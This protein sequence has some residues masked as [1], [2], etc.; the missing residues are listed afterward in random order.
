MMMMK[1]IENNTN[2]L[3]LTSQRLKMS[4]KENSLLYQISN[5]RKQKQSEPLSWESKREK[6]N[7]WTNKNN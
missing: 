6:T 3:P 5:Q 7:E 4:S 2:N 1:V